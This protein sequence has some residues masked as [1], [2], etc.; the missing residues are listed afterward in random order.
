MNKAASGT[1]STPAPPLTLRI[2]EHEKAAECAL[3]RA[4]VESS[5]RRYA[6]L[7][8]VLFGASLGPGRNA[9]AQ[10][11]R[12][13]EPQHILEVGV[14]TGLVLPQYPQEARITGIDLSCEMLAVAQRR[15]LQADE[16][17]IALRVMDA[18]SMDFDDGTFDCVTLPYVLS[19]TPDPDRLVAEVRRVCRPCG[20]I[21]IVNHFSGQPTWR[22]MESL[23]GPLAKWLGFRS[24]FSLEQHILRHSWQVLSIEPTNVL[25]LSKLI[26]I[27]NV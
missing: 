21:V 10:L 8:D 23:L 27:C 22:A 11:V 2:G 9:M 4:H 26:H 6:P 18:E 12:R 7:Y 20:H 14:G 15:V 1:P 3:S 24:Q 5:Y 13:I 16:A 25:A 19:V 17:R